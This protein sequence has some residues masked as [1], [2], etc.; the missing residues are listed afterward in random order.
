MGRR[1]GGL[2]TTLIARGRSETPP[3]FKKL[4]AAGLVLTAVGGALVAAPV[5]LP[6]ALVTIGT[7]MAL[8]GTIMSAVSQLAVKEEEGVQK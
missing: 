1:K 7:Y 8:G 2:V 5:A 6:A 4:R 3:F